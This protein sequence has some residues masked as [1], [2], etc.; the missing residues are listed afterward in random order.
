MLGSNSIHL[1]IHKEIEKLGRELAKHLHM[2][3]S[4]MISSFIVKFS[5]EAENYVIESGME[6]WAVFKDLSWKLNVELKKLKFEV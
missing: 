6:E 1:T 2:S 5:L 3:F 4:R